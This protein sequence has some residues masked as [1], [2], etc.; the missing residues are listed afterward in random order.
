MKG[1]SGTALSCLADSS[2]FLALL[3]PSSFVTE[4]CFVGFGLDFLVSVAF[5]TSAL[6]P[7]FVLPSTFF[8]PSIECFFVD[9][10]AGAGSLAL[11]DLVFAAA[12]AGFAVSALTPFFTAA[13][14]SVLSIFRSMA[15]PIAWR[16]SLVLSGSRPATIFDGLALMLSF[17]ES[18]AE[19]V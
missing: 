5:F 9:E 18:S 13:T 6:S 14:A 11:S 3:W 7:P 15:F 17:A 8:L 12:L 10:P 19:I 4:L 1:S 16:N 2:V